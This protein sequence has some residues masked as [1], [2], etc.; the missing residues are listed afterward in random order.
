MRKI[1]PPRKKFEPHSDPLEREEHREK[2]NDYYQVTE[3]VIR[4]LGENLRRGRNPDG[5]EIAIN[6]ANERAQAIVANQYAGGLILYELEVG[7]YREKTQMRFQQDF[8]LWLAGRSREQEDIDRTQWG[9]QPCFDDPEVRAYLGAFLRKRKEFKLKLAL[10]LTRPPRG[11]LQYYLYFKYIVRGHF[12]KDM[13]SDLGDT[14]YLSDWDILVKAFDDNKGNQPNFDPE[15]PGWPRPFGPDQPKRKGG[16]EDDEG[17]EHQFGPMAGKP[18][19]RERTDPPHYILNPAAPLEAEREATEAQSTEFKPSGEA[20]SPQPDTSS[21]STASP[22]EEQQH[23]NDYDTPPQRIKMNTP[24]PNTQALWDAYAN[25]PEGSPGKKS[26]GETL[27]AIEE[28]DAIAAGDDKGKAEEYYQS[29]PR[30]GKLTKHARDDEPSAGTVDV[31]SASTEV[32]PAKKAPVAAAAPVSPEYG[33][34]TV[35]MLKALLRERDQAVSGRKTELIERLRAYDN[36]N[37]TEEDGDVGSLEGFAVT[38]NSKEAAGEFSKSSQSASV[39]PTSESA[40]SYS[41]A[42]SSSEI[43][44]KNLK[45]PTPEDREALTEFIVDVE[46]YNDFVENL[47]TN[48]NSPTKSM[49]QK[50]EKSVKL[51]MDEEAIIRANT[52]AQQ[53][54]KVPLSALDHKEIGGVFDIMAEEEHQNV[55]NAERILDEWAAYAKDSDAYSKMTQAEKVEYGDPPV[56]PYTIQEKIDAEKVRE[57]ARRNQILYLVYADTA[58]EEQKQREEEEKRKAAEAAAAKKKKKAKPKK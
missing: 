32:S 2:I 21:S 5:E 1:V 33:K 18:R 53:T 28:A 35:P 23:D 7:A 12:S 8:Q 17:V 14:S 46:D 58:I 47:L 6:N 15:H 56:A 26:F 39:A 36:M 9:S 37:K 49:L 42:S 43:A 11:I 45:D 4:N 29:S 3:R 40:G 52:L 38:D 48:P 31:G 19:L 24:G 22:S 34:K 41:A 50:T 55:I 30:P 10:L 13:E 20:P 57:S 16:D 27:K 51:V 25:M 44:V 54:F